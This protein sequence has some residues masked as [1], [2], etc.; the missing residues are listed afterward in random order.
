MGLAQNVVFGLVTGSYIAVAAVGF[1]LI[2]GINDM[3]NFAYGEYMTIG[4]YVGL[5]VGFVLPAGPV[6]SMLLVIAVSAVLGWAVARMFFIPIKDTGPVPL[7]LT[8][9]GVGYILRYLIQAVAGPDLRFFEF[10]QSQTFRTEALGGVFVNM[11]QLTIIAIALVVFGVTHLLLTRTDI[12]LAM[13]ALSKNDDLARVSGI[14]IDS[15]QRYVWLLASGMAGLS[16][17]LIG[18][19]RAAS[20]FMGFNQILIVLTAAI[21]GGAGSAYGA[22][23]GSYVIGVVMA[24]SVGVLPSWATELS[25]AVAFAVLIL[26]LLVKP[27]GIAS[28]E[29]REA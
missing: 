15:V 10:Q 6:V 29:V 4:A 24:T 14:P 2:Y 13:R 11:N 21:L 18:I 16:G 19:Q 22:I 8:S 20:P 28:A 17:Y 27:G 26:V 12:G 5:L 1:T 7:L 23:A 3:I 25:T 9:I